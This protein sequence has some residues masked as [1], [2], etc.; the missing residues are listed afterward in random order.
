MTWTLLAYEDKYIE[1]LHRLVKAIRRDRGGAP[2][3]IESE[4]VGGTGK[5]E[6]ELGPMLGRRDKRTRAPAARV[7]CVADADRPTNLA[8]GSA[9]PR[10]AQETAA[11][12]DAWVVSL[13]DAWRAHLI[14]KARISPDDVPRVAVCCV[15]WSK[16]SLLIACPDALIEHAGINAEEVRDQI[17]ACDPD[18]DT[19]PDAEYCVRYQSPSRCMDQVIKRGS[20]RR[21]KKGRDDEDI[22][23]IIASDPRRLA[24][25]AARCPDIARLADMI[26]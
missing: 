10:P 13:E 1:H 17:R 25:V 19:T 24:Q 9:P 18:P 4:S 5:F 15:R 3:V 8:A 12:L 11:T 2:C 23:N 20:G 21:Y 6:R 14:A 26:L 16:E 7:I 22:L